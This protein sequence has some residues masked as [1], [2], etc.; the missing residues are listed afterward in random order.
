MESDLSKSQSNKVPTGPEMV[1]L[2]LSYRLPESENCI[3]LKEPK[4]KIY[5]KLGEMERLHGETEAVK[6]C[7]EVDFKT[8]FMMYY[9]FERRQDVRF[10]ILSHEE[11]GWES[12]A[13][14]STYL[15]EIIGT[16]D[17]TI[18]FRVSSKA[19]THGKL[20]IRSEKVQ[21]T[22]STAF[23]DISAR[24]LSSG[25]KLFS[26]GSFYFVLNRVCE[27]DELIEVY[28]SEVIKKNVNPKWIPFKIPM[29]T[30]CQNQRDA[31]LRIQIFGHKYFG[32]K[33]FAQCDFTVE[34]LIQLKTT[35]CVLSKPNKKKKYG[36]LEVNNFNLGDNP[37]LTDFFRDGF[38]LN[39]VIGT[40][41]SASKAPSN[42]DVQSQELDLRVALYNIYE[43][44][45]PYLPDKKAAFYGIGAKPS[46]CQ[47]PGKNFTLSG[48]PADPYINRL[49]RLKG[50]VNGLGNVETLSSLY[51]PII[52]KAV[53]LAKQSKATGSKEYVVAVILTKGAIHDVET[54][55]KSLLGCD[56][57]PISILI[58]GIGEKRFDKLELFEKE[59]FFLTVEKLKR[60]F[61]HFYKS[62]SFDGVETMLE[63]SLKEIPSQFLEYMRN[64]DITVG[65]KKK[66]DVRKILATKKTFKLDDYA[67]VGSRPPKVGNL[68]DIQAVPEM[69]R[70][71]VNID[72]GDLKNE[73]YLFKN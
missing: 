18:V 38:N 69:R 23:I 5:T 45:S 41:F 51:E 61:V 2:F 47:E 3:R 25:S 20:I 58:L 8:A 72:M 11:K 28:K 36:F 37:S 40:D 55:L 24:K 29:E 14:I 64:S 39:L 10:E 17:S 35:E 63:E 7:L 21:D 32:Y 27:G 67:G 13:S 71:S 1:Q 50:I 65:P 12:I 59:G 22:N 44:L 42:E 30:L 60:T 70:K 34:E 48:N 6:D 33:L 62:G 73:S 54:T 53:K 68:L 52:E 31:N 49:E 26:A 16:K 43:T 9:H 46:G 4:V 57:L 19:G 56:V 66:V 15:G